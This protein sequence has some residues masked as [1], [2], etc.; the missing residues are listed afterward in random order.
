MA[1]KAHPMPRQSEQAR[2]SSLMPYRLPVFWVAKKFNDKLIS[3]F[4]AHGSKLSR[5]KKE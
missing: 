3:S 2:F 4:T 5:E 1:N